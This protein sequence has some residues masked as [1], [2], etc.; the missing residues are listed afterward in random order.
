MGGDALA[1]QEGAKE[2]VPGI[3]LDVELDAD[4]LNLSCMIASFQRGV[5]L[6]DA[7]VAYTNARRCLPSRARHPAFHPAVVVEQLVGAAASAGG[8]S[9]AQESYPGWQQR[10]MIGAHRLRETRGDPAAI[11]AW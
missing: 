8:Q 9:G 6:H 11:R 5:W 7:H 4:R 10:G 3:V 2:C 1:R